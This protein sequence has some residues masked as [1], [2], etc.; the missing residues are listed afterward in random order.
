MRLSRGYIEGLRR[1]FAI[2]EKSYPVR[3]RRLKLRTLIKAYRWRRSDLIQVY[4]ILHHFDDLDYTKF[5]K[6][7]KGGQTRG[8]TLKLVKLRTTSRLRQCSR[9]MCI[10]NG[11]KALKKQLS[12]QNQ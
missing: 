7:A 10:E 6:L 1:F 5:F 4:R 8:H 12:L 9:I 3:L 2:S 11:W